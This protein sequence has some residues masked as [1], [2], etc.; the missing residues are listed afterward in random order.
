MFNKLKFQKN[1]AC[2]F[3]KWKYTWNVNFVYI[4]LFSY[5][6]NS[7]SISYINVQKSTDFRLQE[8]RER[9]TGHACSWGEGARPQWSEIKNL[10]QILQSLQNFEFI[11]LVHKQTFFVKKNFPRMVPKGTYS[12]ESFPELGLEDA[13]FYRSAQN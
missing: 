11:T 4:I 9:K 8:K 13:K 6:W 1:F 7:I 3:I 5:I 12:Y 10:V 2:L